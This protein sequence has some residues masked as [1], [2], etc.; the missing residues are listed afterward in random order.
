[1]SNITVKNLSP[2]PGYILV[3][4]AISSNKTASGLYLP[5]SA[6]E[7]L[8]LDLPDGPLEFGYAVD[9]CWTPVEPPVNDPVEDLIETGETIF[10]LASEE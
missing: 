3:E 4:P 2:L 1:M 5:E 6:T 9:V 7:K 8:M 10:T